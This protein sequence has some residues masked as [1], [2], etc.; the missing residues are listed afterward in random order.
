MLRGFTTETQ[1]FLDGKV[2]VV[3][4]TAF[5]IPVVIGIMG[6]FAGG[7]GVCRRLHGGGGSKREGIGLLIFIRIISDI[8]HLSDMGKPFSDKVAF[9]PRRRFLRRRRARL[10]AGGV[11]VGVMWSRSMAWRFSGS[12]K[13]LVLGMTVLSCLGLKLL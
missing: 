8:V 12:E 10:Q 4:S 9:C 6:V 13:F 2:E 1:R 7:L 5:A 3:I 11:E